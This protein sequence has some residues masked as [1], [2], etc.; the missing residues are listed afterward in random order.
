MMKAIIGG[1]ETRHPSTYQMSRPNGLP[2]Y[3]LLI[4]KTHG[5]FYLNGTSFS[6]DSGDALLIS[7]E[8]PYYYGN[9]HGDYV[10]DWIHFEIKDRE[11]KKQIDS[12][13]NAPFPIGNAESYT[14]CIRQILWELSYGSHKYKDENINALF[15]ILFNHL[16]AAHEAG[17]QPEVTLPYYSELQLLRLEI[18][19]SLSD[20]HSIKEHARSLKV[21]ESYFQH[22]YKKYFGISFRHDLIQIRI[23]HAKYLLLTSCLPVQQ[24]AEV[25]GYTNEVHF[26]RQFKK[27]TGISPAKFRKNTSL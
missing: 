25:C 4:I 9:P 26:Y 12:I 7:P 13:A 22:L 20:A 1:Y 17:K 16:F 14:L 23:N 19:N 27:M 18:G 21:S 6:A 8:I 15:Q 3:V 24:I 11:L 2:H 10:D 5:E